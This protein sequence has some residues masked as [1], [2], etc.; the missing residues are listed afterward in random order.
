MRAMDACGRQ[1]HRQHRLRR[2]TLPV[3]PRFNRCG[4]RS[5][6]EEPMLRR[7]RLI[8][9]VG[10]VSILLTGAAQA[11]SV[12]QTLQKY[13]LVG[14]W[15][16]DCSKTASRQNEYI[17]IRVI[18][19]NTGQ[20]DIMTGPQTTRAYFIDRVAVGWPDQ[21]LHISMD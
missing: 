4:W 11:Q 3:L 10:L 1:H 6:M 9:S 16:I 15:S 12:S 5:R 18:D 2:R 14:I 8:A 13:E 17:V 20:Y 7:W 21:Q 19:D